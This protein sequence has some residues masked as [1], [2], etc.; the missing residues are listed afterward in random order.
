MNSISG[1]FTSHFTSAI[2]VLAAVALAISCG[3]DD[4]RAPVGNYDDVVSF[5]DVPA[6]MQDAVSQG[7]SF[8][9]LARETQPV[10]Q[11][12]HDFR[13]SKT[14]GGFEVVNPIYWI[15]AAFS[16]NDVVITREDHDWVWTYRLSAVGRQK[17]LLPVKPA[18]PEVAGCRAKDCLSRLEYVRGPIIE[19]YQNTLLGIEQGFVI[20]QAP[21]GDG[22]LLIVGETSGNVTPVIRDAGQTIQYLKDDEHAFT[23]STLFV[24]DALGQ[25]IPVMADL[26]Q[27]QL[28]LVIDDSEAT[29][30]LHV[31]PEIGDC[32]SDWCDD[33]DPATIDVCYEGGH[34]CKHSFDTAYQDKPCATGKYCCSTGFYS[35]ICPEAATSGCEDINDESCATGGQC[36]LCADFGPCNLDACSAFSGGHI[37]C[38]HEFDPDAEGTSCAPTDFFCCIK[39]NKCRA[40]CASV[41]GPCESPTSCSD[42]DPTT[43][44]A[45]TVSGTSEVCDNSKFETSSEGT[46]CVVENKFCCADT[47][48]SS[49]T[50][51]DQCAASKCDDKNNCTKDNCTNFDAESD[52][53]TCTHEFDADSAGKDC[54]TGDFCCADDGP[55]C[56]QICPA[57]CADGF[58]PPSEPKAG[59]TAPDACEACP[60][61]T[62]TKTGTCTDCEDGYI[63]PEPG[64]AECTACDAGQISKAPHT[65]CEACPAGTSSAAG[66]GT[67][68]GCAAG[69]VPDGSGGC[70]ACGSGSVAATGALTCTQCQ[71]GTIPKDNTTCDPCGAGEYNDTPGSLTCKKCSAGSVPNEGKTDCDACA[72]GSAAAEGDA[73]CTECKA[74]EFSNEKKS[75]DPCAPGQISDAKASSCKKCPAGQAELSDNACADCDTG[76]A[77]STD[78]STCEVCPLGQIDDGGHDD[79]VKCPAGQYQPFASVQLCANCADGTVPNEDAS[80]CTK[81]ETGVAAAGD[82]V[83]KECQ[84][85][86]VAKNGTTCETCAAGSVAEKGDTA[87]KQCGPGTEAN[88]SKCDPCKDGYT[89][90][91]GLACTICA[92]N[93]VEIDNACVAC[94]PGSSALAGSFGATA[95]EKCTPCGPGTYAS[96]AGTCAQCAAGQVPSSPATGCSECDP[97]FAAQVGDATCTQCVAG[98]FDNGATC[99]KCASG[100]V[101]GDE[102]TT[103]NVCAEG[104]KPNAGQTD[105]DKCPAGQFLFEGTVCK[106]CP[107]GKKQPEAGKTSCIDCGAG[108]ISILSGTDCKTCGVGEE[109]VNNT[110]QACKTD[111][112]SAGA[113]DS[114]TECGAGSVT[115]KDGSGCVLCAGGHYENDSHVCAACDPGEVQ[116]SEGSTSCSVCTAGQYDDQ[117]SEVCKSCADGFI[118][119]KAGQTSCDQ[120]APGKKDN[121]NDEC[122]ACAKFTGSG[123]GATSC[124]AYAQCSVGTSAPAHNNHHYLYINTSMGWDAAE[125]HCVGLG[126]HLATINDEAEN[127]ELAARA[128]AKY[129]IGR[130]DK[131]IE[132]QY[133]WVDG[134]IVSPDY[135][136]YAS[137]E[138][139]GGTKENCTEAVPTSGVWNDIPCSGD[140]KTF[141]CEFSS[142]PTHNC[143]ADADCKEETPGFGCDCKDGY[144][145]NGVSCDQCAGGTKDVDDKCVP[146]GA[147]Q[148]SG[149]GATDCTQCGAGEYAD[150]TE[151][152]KCPA[153]QFEDSNVC[154]SCPTGG[155]APEGSTGCT[156]CK[157]GEFAN[158]A[159]C[160]A[161]DAGEYSA[162]DADSCTPC[163][164]GTYA[165][166]G[167][168]GCVPCAPGTTSA[169]G[170]KNVDECNKCPAGKFET[171]DQ[172][173]C[174]DCDDGFFSF[175]GMTFCGPCFAGSY[176]D[177]A[178]T[179]CF[180][181]DLGEYSSVGQKECTK[182]AAGTYQNKLHTDCLACDTGH[183]AP[184]GSI[185]C[186]AC[187]GGTFANSATCDDCQPGSY[188]ADLADTCTACPKGQVQPAAGKT[189]CIEC[190]SG[191]ATG[192]VLVLRNKLTPAFDDFAAALTAAGLQVTLS[193][194]GDYD[195]TNPAPEEFDAVI[196][197]RDIDSLAAS[198]QQ[199]LVDYVQGGGTFTHDF[200]FGAFA[201]ETMNELRLFDGMDGPNASVLKVVPGQESH[202]LLSDLPSQFIQVE[203]FAGFA[204]L[205]LFESNPSTVVMTDS[206]YPAVVARHVGLGRVV[207][208]HHIFSPNPVLNDPTVRQLY[209]NAVKWEATGTT[210]TTFD[211]GTEV[212]TTQCAAGFF[213][214][215]KTRTCD[216]CSAG[217]ASG[218]P[219]AVDA[220]PVCKDGYVQPDTGQISCI[221]CADTNQFDDGTEIC[222][223]QCVAGKFGNTLT[224]TCD[225]CGA[226]TASAE[227]GSVDKCP[228]C[229][230]GQVQPDEGKTSCIKCGATSQ[231]DDGT[232]VC[233]DSC[234]AGKFGNTT[235]ATCDDC[236]AGTAS[237]TSGSVD[238][239]TDCDDGEVQPDKG[240]TSCIK[241]GATS[242]FDDGTEVCKT[243]C[244]AGKFGNTTTA[245]CDDCGKGTASA[246]SGSVD[247]CKDCDDGE[248]QP[249]K[250]KTGC[251]KCSD[252]KQF[253]DGTEVCKDSCV[254][255]KFGNKTTATCDNCGKGTASAK[256]G[257]EDKCPDCDPGYVQP[258]EGKTSC[259]YCGDSSEF[260]NGTEVCAAQCVAGKFGNPK[261]ATCDA[262]AK[263]TASDK[264]GAVGKCPDCDGGYVQPEPGKTSCIHCGD[265]N[266][267][268]N[269]TEVC[270]DQCVAGQFGNK[271]TATCDACAIGTA[272]KD[273]GSVDKCPACDPGQVQ[274]EKGKTQCIPCG[275]GQ[276]G[277]VLIVADAPSPDL[278]GLVASLQSEGMN[279]TLSSKPFGQYDG[280]DQ[281]EKSFGAIIL[282]NLAG[283]PMPLEGQQ[284]VARNSRQTAV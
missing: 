137:N 255:G 48:K 21:T 69:S 262:C 7:Q 89:S 75:C 267:F 231:F 184:E 232:E 115:T 103:C 84:A 148:V 42:G 122:V 34:I 194:P 283:D 221:P 246:T 215:T 235:T 177:G 58:Q 46:T 145:G 120:C 207:G 114:C 172:T 274:P 30:P 83:C 214:N 164:A 276:A 252:S 8:V 2:S 219:G 22:P 72:D 160:K 176:E 195:G 32:P 81:C 23:Y 134:S 281:L 116:A 132:G 140:N 238:K 253:D 5:V 202:P 152:K 108:G 211:D 282:F 237:A 271:T 113:V 80:D 74:G 229:D 261:S 284:A 165:N 124:V 233:K 209:V 1:R 170:A 230:P 190:G 256:S 131:Q 236:G 250:G 210:T 76:S 191:L 13:F 173:E 92:A 54:T 264:S 99:D 100:K 260:D 47:L 25:S 188:S 151:C 205:R 273:A 228:A 178:N 82:S 17:T 35:M 88:V 127:K 71:A 161:C 199:T 59:D 18:S 241:C 162:D 118:Q 90:T 147:G 136:N 245:T 27:D 28:I 254:A 227:A 220:C 153:G 248:V 101:S 163:P 12:L 226:G 196:L 175:A 181:C 244:Q 62:A 52:T 242:Q 64:A 157:A 169:Q 4:R 91:G 6:T 278:D 154:K 159:A 67:C 39:D 146:C 133:Q 275:T 9:P 129:H 240:K 192:N 269:D 203:G 95:A 65:A 208:F 66:S 49:A 197:A 174:D 265:T 216:P 218:K 130:N 272:S 201:P 222:K 40:D 166:S 143:A 167:G 110:C 102:A 149:A 268:D 186:T 16:P 257:A 63:A 70:T 187:K 43:Q 179:G 44:D 78:G 189:A 33:K 68:S 85:G 50:C 138:P 73:T 193:D 239:C 180:P 26:D 277:D 224:A 141:F 182:C 53:Q 97:G 279:A 249:N 61:G 142:D 125:S 94:A 55:K 14:A 206:T 168:T 107:D 111:F 223:S 171:G 247:K 200:L 212:C 119:P 98:Q 112:A 56:F 60:A 117:V 24:V 79:C 11:P 280:S 185:A 128:T 77:P 217:T 86:E 158:G 20:N 204:Q 105:C 96:S 123:G 266:Q 183:A 87:C 150:V 57:D 234:V 36:K 29:Y 37:A 19:W 259:V 251:I 51:E 106:A 126:G 109:V 198:A 144:E 258:L 263:G 10:V 139:N 15:Q 155:V 104:S 135:T 41:V 243:E 225:D 38:S 45:C 93:T 31:D 213:G 156:Q 270:A 121:G 3:N